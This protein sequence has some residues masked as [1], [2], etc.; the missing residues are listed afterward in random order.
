MA[1]VIWSDPFRGASNLAGR[2]KVRTIAATKFYHPHE[3]DLR[4][5]WECRAGQHSA[6]ANVDILGWNL[7]MFELPGVE[8]DG[9]SGRNV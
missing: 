9:M 4:E 1:R 6:K 5:S 8:E 7:L 2:S 3:T